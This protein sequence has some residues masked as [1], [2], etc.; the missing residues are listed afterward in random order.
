MMRTN[1]D[2]AADFAAE[3]VC[4]GAFHNRKGHGGS[5]DITKRVLTREQLRRLLYAAINRS[6]DAERYF[7]K[8]DSE[9]RTSI[10]DFVKVIKC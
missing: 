10:S 2:K 9:E 7:A 5:V 8:L 4:R 6:R 3:A 1:K